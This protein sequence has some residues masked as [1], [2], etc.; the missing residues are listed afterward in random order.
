MTIKHMEP[1]IVWI[2]VSNLGIRKSRGACSLGPFQWV[3]RGSSVFVGAV[4]VAVFDSINY[5]IWKNFLAMIPSCK[6][7]LS[8]KWWARDEESPWEK[9]AW[10]SHSSEDKQMYAGQE[11]SSNLSE[12]QWPLVLIKYRVPRRGYLTEC[13]W[14]YSDTWYR[15]EFHR[16][17]QSWVLIL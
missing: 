1:I 17:S 5:G 4:V 2:T 11:G 12:T 9:P 7:I 15:P 3:L 6:N 8:V 10:T 13:W 16:V 14:N